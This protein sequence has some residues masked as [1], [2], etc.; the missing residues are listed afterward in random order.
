MK[1]PGAFKVNS[2]YVRADK[3]NAERHGRDRVQGTVGTGFPV[4]GMLP[5]VIGAMMLPIAERGLVVRPEAAA[6]NVCSDR[7]A[8]VPAVTLA[9]VMAALQSAA[10]AE[11]MLEEVTVS[12]QRRS[13]PLLG[14]P[15]AVTVVGAD[16]LGSIGADTLHGVQESVPGFSVEKVQG[17]SN[18]AI[19]GV[20][21]GGRNIGFEARTGVYIDDVYMGQPQALGLPLLDIERVEIL[22]GPQGYLF[23]RNTVSG[24][25]S[26][27]TRPPGDTLQASLRA[28]AGS[29]NLREIRGRVSAPLGEAVAWALSAGQATRDG[30]G[31]NLSGGELDDLSRKAARGRLRYSPGDRTAV[32]LHADYAEIRRD[33]V[34][35]G[36]PVT[37]FFDTP[38]SE[39]P[40]PPRVTDINT[41]SYEDVR[42]RG[43]NVTVNHLFPGGYL[44]TAVTGVRN[45]E[46][47]RQND[48]DYSRNDILW[49]N[50]AERYR[51][52]SQELRLAS[53]AERRLRYLAGFVLLEEDARAGRRAV[54]GED[55]DAVVPLP[56]GVRAPVGAALGLTP[57]AVTTIDSRIRTRSAALFGGLDYALTEKLTASLGL[58]YTDESKTLRHDLD[59]SGSGGFGIAVLPDVRDR[60]ADRALTPSLGLA[61]TVAPGIN[62]YASYRSAFKSGGW[63]LDFLTAAQTTAGIVFEDESVHAYEVGVK[64][65][66]RRLSFETALFL[67]DYADHQVFQSIRRPDGQ[68]VFVLAN[69]ARARTRGVEAALGV[70]LGERLTLAGSLA[71]VDARYRSFPGGGGPGIDLDGNRLQAAPRGNAAV[72]AEYALPAGGGGIVLFGEYT[73]RGHSYMQPENSLLDRLNSRRLLNARLTWRPTSEG[74]WDVSL[75]VRNLLDEEYFDRRGRDFLGNQYVHYGDPRTY[76]IEIELRL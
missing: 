9:I 74:P 50:Y 75:W 19:R 31:I 65:G 14:V 60:R 22:R 58:R 61:Y 5:V 49:V 15:M 36:E 55:M 73:Y 45:T 8:R 2:W 21:G 20:G 1:T 66:L 70:R 56:G 52:R 39:L 72:S 69:A 67:A 41:P 35:T 24:A 64:A 62:L 63:N 48:S 11:W 44:M 53:P 38:H 33:T 18:I 40:R 6:G 42:L 25:V 10:G 28:N 59:G 57:G 54:L 23:G 51:Q 17:Y 47:E 46:Q 7:R 32:D 16:T 27:V 71:L 13:E 29:H 34:V 76:G 3:R 37:D 30:F 26:I 43:G 4:D 68:S 12:A